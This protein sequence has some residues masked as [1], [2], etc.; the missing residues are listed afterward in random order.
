MSGVLAEHL[1]AWHGIVRS[2]DA[3]RHQYYV[4]YGPECHGFEL[5]TARPNRGRPYRTARPV[6]LGAAPEPPAPETAR[7]DFIEPRLVLSEGRYPADLET[8]RVSNLMRVA[9]E[10]EL[11]DAEEQWYMSTV[12]TT[13]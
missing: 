11:R 4:R 13:V 6:P 1:F 8:R 5:S 3:V 9:L 12:R 10:P 2:A 7:V